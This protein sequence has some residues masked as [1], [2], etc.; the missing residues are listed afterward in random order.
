MARHP[1]LDRLEAEIARLYRLRE[2]ETAP[3]PRRLTLQ[4]YRALDAGERA[5]IFSNPYWGDRIPPLAELDHD[6][7]WR[8]YQDSRNV[9]LV[10]DA[11]SDDELEQIHTDT[12]NTRLAPDDRRGRGFSAAELRRL[13]DDE[14]M[15]LHREMI[16]PM[17][18]IR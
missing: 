8:L 10:P 5:Q 18:E 17:P 7:L 14:L 1:R 13:S 12:L 6:E 3:P 9:P 4:E 2:A 15:K 11:Y 16:K